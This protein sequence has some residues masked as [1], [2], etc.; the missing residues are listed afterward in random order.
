VRLF[1]ALA[2]VFVAILAGCGGGNGDGGDGDGGAPPRQW[3]TDVCGALSTWLEDLQ[4]RQTQVTSDLEGVTDL[5][6][7]RGVLVDFLDDAVTETDTMIGE[8]EAAGT[9]DVDMGAELQQ[10][11]VDGIG[12][13]KTAFEEAKTTAEELPT[14]NQ[15]EF[16]QGTSD[17]EQQLNTQS[18]AIE[19]AF[20]ELDQKYDVP[21]LDEAFDEEPACQDFT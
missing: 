8:V 13:A 9:P 19:D 21:E 20:D 11:F 4:D 2:L 7:V 10:D 5:T 18:Q 15:A 1:A 17:I 14:D 6:E 3:A 12:Q 16:A